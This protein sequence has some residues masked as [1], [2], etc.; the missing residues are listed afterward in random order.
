VSA[1]RNSSP[2]TSS[3]QSSFLL[4]APEAK[5]VSAAIRGAGKEARSSI[6]KRLKPA[7]EIIAVEIRKRTPRGATHKLEESTRVRPGDMSVRVVNTAVAKGTK[8]KASKY[9]GYRYGKRLEFD[10]LFGGR[11]AFFYPGFAAKKEEAVRELRRI[12]DDVMHEL[13]TGGA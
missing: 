1:F 6:R 12:L 13:K 11:Y 3:G 10:P 2:K 5:A 7:G 9:K 4:S 8:R